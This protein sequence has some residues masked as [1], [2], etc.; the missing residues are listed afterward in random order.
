MLLKADFLPIG[1]YIEEIQQ[2]H[3]TISVVELD[4]GELMRYEGYISRYRWRIK[5]L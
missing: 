2:V 1:K 3:R 4:Q 5:L